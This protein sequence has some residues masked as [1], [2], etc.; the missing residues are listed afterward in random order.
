MSHSPRELYPKM[1]GGR[2]GGLPILR[3]FFDLLQIGRTIDSHCPPSPTMKITHGEAIEGLLFSIFQGDHRLYCVNELLDQY[4]CKVLFGRKDIEAGQFHDERLGKGLDAFNLS[5]RAILGDVSAHGL[6]LL[7]KP[8]KALIPDT[9]S[10]S[11]YGEDYEERIK[12]DIPFAF[13]IF[14]FSKDHRPDLRQIVVNLMTTVFGFPVDGDILDGNASDVETFRDDLDSMAA[15][16][17]VKEKTPMI[18]DSKL[19]TFPTLL[20]ASNLGIPIITIT[21]ETLKIREQLIREFSRKSDLPLLLK[22]ESG[23]MYHGASV[24]LPFSFEAK[25]QSPK[26]VWLRFLV[27]HSS[28]LAATKA[29]GRKILRQK[30]AARLEKWAKK[31]G[32]HKFACEADARKY[33][34]KEWKLE[35]ASFHDLSIVITRVETQGKRKP[36]RPS[37]DA[38]S[39]PPEISHQVTCTFSLRSQEES[40]WDPDG[41]FVLTTTIADQRNK[42]DLEILEAYRSRDVVEKNFQWMKGPLA[43]A[44]VF[45]K[46]PSRIRALGFVFI[47]ALQ[48]FALIQNLFREAMKTWGETSPHPGR[49]RSKA[50][51]TRGILEVMRFVDFGIFK[52]NGQTQI[53][54]RGFNGPQMEILAILGLQ[55]LYIRKIAAVYDDNPGK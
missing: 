41:M 19:F 43:L 10:I 55:D 29:E 53:I 33:A 54:W 39:L 15:L 34:E 32:K 1:E 26:T 28:Q 6:R 14:G 38:V 3:H 8:V 4:D 36:G 48:I 31:L 50:P 22:T 21:P 25:G 51:T 30:E 17:W 27:V 23:E 2:L 24:T 12:E 49:K 47:L 44:P 9:T 37:V 35:K 16:P 18:G 40:T 13:P 5:A 52:M 7:G 46:T 42:S 11:V 45:L 20:K